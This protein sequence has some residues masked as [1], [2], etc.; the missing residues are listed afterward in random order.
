MTSRKRYHL[1]KQLHIVGNMIKLTSL[2]SSIIFIVLIIAL[3]LNQVSCFCPRY[4]GVKAGVQVSVINKSASSNILDPI[5]SL[6][7]NNVNVG[8]YNTRSAL[9]MAQISKKE[10]QVGIDK[11]VKVLQKDKRACDELGELQ[12]N[13]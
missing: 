10:A 8:K 4:D 11:V 5:I 6:A 3:C 9:C 7:Y 2:L 12:K 1:R 13:S